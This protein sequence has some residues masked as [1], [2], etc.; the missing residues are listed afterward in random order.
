MQHFEGVIFMLALLVGLSAIADKVRAPF[1]VL[2]VIAGVAIA[3]VPGFPVIILD[4]EV[5]FLLFLPPLLYDAASHT[6]WHEFWAE[7][8]PISTLAI[9]LVFFTTL[10]VAITAHYSI[11]GFSWPLA[12]V[13]GAIVSP[14]DAA[15]ATSIIKGLKLNKRVITILEGES[16]IN[17]ASALI[18]YRFGVIA[19]STGSFVIWK[20][21]LQF[22]LLTCGGIL[23]GIAVGYLFVLMHKKIRHNS[24]VSTS[25]TL[26]TPFIS[27]LIAEQLHTSGVLAVVSTGLFMSWRSPE[28]FSYQTRMRSRSVWDTL[29]FILNGF[30]FL[31]IGQQLPAV[32]R[33]LGNYPLTLLLFY[34]L[35]VSLIVIVVRITWV[36]AGA[37]TQNITGHKGEPSR[38]KEAADERKNTWKNVLIVAWTGT[39]G[40]VSLATALALPLTLA[41]GRPFPQR[42]LILFLTFVVIFVTLI[43]QGLSLPLLIRI[44]N[45]KPAA[46]PDKEEKE[47]RLFIA[48]AT[49]DFIENDFP[50][51]IDE[52]L[53]KQLKA[54]Y[55]ITISRLLREMEHD[56]KRTESDLPYHL[57]T[58]LTPLLTAQIKTSKFQR[59]LLL[60]IHKEGAYSNQ[61][62]RKVEQ[63]LD[64]DDLRLNRLIKKDDE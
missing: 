10:A 11:P 35:I 37:Y 34:G 1:P 28:T 44:L 15:A 43:V 61:T 7:I 29:V 22:L 3:F 30:V 23:S 55:E 52:S 9:T 50:I 45:V 64:Q 26:L 57:L 20:A 36:F 13:L 14:P 63:E 8:R 59:E 32:L 5:V 42:S 54:Q 18:A 60:K 49:T 53:K 16:L 58:P 25:L 39:R 56:S 19:L 47:L 31:L 6:S 41:G 48:Q 2:L 51:D 27:Y 4:P 46:R 40:I 17:D 62:I 33:E 38:L 24:I 12:F 21:G